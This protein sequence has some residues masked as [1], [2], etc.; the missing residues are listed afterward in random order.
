MYIVLISR[1]PEFPESYF[2]NR[3]EPSDTMRKS[4]MKGMY[5]YIYIYITY[6]CVHIYIY[7]YIHITHTDNI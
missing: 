1:T 3:P 6:T 7:I 2:A 4:N 5:I